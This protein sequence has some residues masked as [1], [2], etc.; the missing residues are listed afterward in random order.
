MYRRA[1]FAVL[2]AVLSFL[3]TQSAQ[4]AGPFQY[5]SLTPCRLIDTRDGSGASNEVAGP[6]SNPGP[7]TFRVQ[8]F[9]GIPA[10]ADAVSLNVTIVTPSTG[11]D[12]RLFPSNVGQPLV[13]MLNYNA[14]EPALANGAILPVAQVAGDDIAMAIGMA[15]GSNGCG[16][17]HVL[18]DVTGYFDSP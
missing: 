9:C 18:M 7:H 8:G 13:S 6:R 10:G 3:A 14:G 16:S 2:L 1:C 17:V 11:G 5:H 15:C 4:A 12:L